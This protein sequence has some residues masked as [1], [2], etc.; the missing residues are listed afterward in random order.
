M[1]INEF[2]EQMDLKKACTN[3]GDEF[4]FGKFRL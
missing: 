1:K 2:N 4:I 3:W